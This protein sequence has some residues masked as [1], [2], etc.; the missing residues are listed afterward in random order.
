MTEILLSKSRNYIYDTTPDFKAWCN[1]IM[2]KIDNNF[3]FLLYK[4]KKKQLNTKT[5]LLRHYSY[6]II[7]QNEY[8][9]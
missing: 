3:Q 4:I 5:Y 6:R 8:P 9:K 2:K 7:S 1:A